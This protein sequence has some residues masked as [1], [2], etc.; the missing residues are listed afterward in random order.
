MPRMVL[1]FQTQG[2]EGSP[3]TSLPEDELQQWLSEGLRELCQQHKHLKDYLRLIPIEE[4]G[5]P[6]Y[7][8][9]L[10]RDMG[11]KLLNLIYPVTDDVFVH[12]YSDASGGRGHYIP[13]EPDL[14]ADL[15]G[16]LPEVESK[17]IDVADNLYGMETNEE[18]AE[19]LLKAVATICDIKRNGASPN[20]PKAKSK[21]ND[22]EKAKIQM[23]PEQFEAVKYVTVRDRVGLGAIEPLLHDPNLEDISQSGVGHL[24]VEHK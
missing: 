5:V 16:L 24:F 13:I 6:E 3:G 22:R 20:P 14:T 17:L 18:R 11:D 12:I 15:A 2:E 4:I 10:S 7:Y 23:T 19:A 1:P 8:D 9:K 21:K